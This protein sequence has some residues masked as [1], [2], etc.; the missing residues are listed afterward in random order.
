MNEINLLALKD[1]KLEKESVDI[2]NNLTVVQTASNSGDL[3]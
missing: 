2:L 3:S 1:D